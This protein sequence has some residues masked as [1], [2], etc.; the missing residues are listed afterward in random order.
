MNRTRSMLLSLALPLLL[1]GPVAAD[2]LLVD[3]IQ[4]AP[5]IQT[6]RAGL[7]M[8]SVRQQFGNP[9]AEQ[10]TVSVDGG[11]FQPPITRW[12]YNAFSV[13]FE[14]DRVV[15]SVVHRQ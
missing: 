4:S 14:R 8:A 7:D 10:P 3:S 5:A 12:D 1:A 2:E 13:F 15:H 11:P 6:P 9:V